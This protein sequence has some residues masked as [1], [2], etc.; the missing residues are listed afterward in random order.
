M[1][2]QKSNLT[3]DQRMM[4]ATCRQVVDTVVVPF[5]RDDRTREWEMDPTARLA[6]QI[7]EQA[8]AAAVTHQVRLALFYDANLD[9]GAMAGR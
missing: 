7:L 9:I 5:I 6:P 8:D 3:A 4:R 1:H 2:W